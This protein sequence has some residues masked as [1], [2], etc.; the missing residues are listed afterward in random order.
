MSIIN[1]KLESKLA[2][3]QWLSGFGRS[4]KQFYKMPLIMTA[5]P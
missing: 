2:L 3:R 5:T 4:L 1:L